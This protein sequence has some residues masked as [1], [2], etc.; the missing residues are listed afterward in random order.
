MHR[1]IATEANEG[2]EDEI[3]RLRFLR[4][5]LFKIR[6]PIYGLRS[7][8]NCGPFVAGMLTDLLVPSSVTLAVFLVQLAG[9]ASTP[10]CSNAKLAVLANGQ[11]T[12]TSAP[13]RST[14][15]AGRGSR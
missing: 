15:S 11:E 5:L 9:A 6:P 3:R 12:I 10:A 1:E 2:N 8:K 7:R 13:E 4:Y 14:E